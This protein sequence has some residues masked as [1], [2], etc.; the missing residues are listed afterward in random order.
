MRL[1]SRCISHGKYRICAAVEPLV[2]R[3]LG[4]DE[5]KS[6]DEALCLTRRL[7]FQRIEALAAPCVSEPQN[8]IV[9]TRDPS[10]V[11]LCLG[12]QRLARLAT[13]DDNAINQI[14][15]AVRL[16]ENRGM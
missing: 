5:E 2:G 14:G 3:V 15:C 9:R 10:P 7:S 11:V 13:S 1:P 6:P 12:E 16:P 4:A 8:R